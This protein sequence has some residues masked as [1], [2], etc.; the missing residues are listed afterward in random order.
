LS[1]NFALQILALDLLRKKKDGYA[2]E[3]RSVFR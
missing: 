3:C 1:Y 2:V